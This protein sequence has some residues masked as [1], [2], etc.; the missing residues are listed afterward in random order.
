MVSHVPIE[1]ANGSR[2]GQIRADPIPERPEDRIV[3]VEDAEIQY[4]AADGPR[5]EH[6]LVIAFV[7]PEV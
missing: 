2:V 3:E 1:Q 5:R 4:S 6:H 7:V